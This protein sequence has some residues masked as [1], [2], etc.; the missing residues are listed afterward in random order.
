MKLNIREYFYIYRRAIRFALTGLF[1]TGVHAVIAIVLIQYLSLNPPV[2]NGAAFLGA[3]VI[4]YVI[5]T[6]WTFLAQMHG[7]TLFRF[8]SVSIFGFLLAMLVAWVVQQLGY[9][10]F[11]GVCSVAL[12]LPPI[13]FLLHNFWTY[14]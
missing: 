7:R 11:A 12:T 8:V 13:T 1:V 5:N 9:S 10:S 2:A 6:T 14:R 3:T 4:S